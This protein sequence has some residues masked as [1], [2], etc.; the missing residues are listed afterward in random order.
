MLVALILFGIGGFSCTILA[1]FF[2]VRGIKSKSWPMVEG[3][4]LKSTLS[5]SRA[6]SEESASYDPYIFYEYKV[7][8]VSYTS[9]Q[10][11]LRETAL[12]FFTRR[13]AERLVS[14]YAPNTRVKVYYNPSRPT[15]SVLEPGITKDI[16][17]LYLLL[18]VVCI[19]IFVFL[20]TIW[21]N[22]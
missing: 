15:Q 7:G 11:D 2:I 9:D 1:I 6:T 8:G 22:S 10:V 21:L 14:K 19:V 13:P 16:F 17:Y 18:G 12:V 5:E 4:I 3:T 20:F